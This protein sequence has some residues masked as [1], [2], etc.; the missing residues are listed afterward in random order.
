MFIVYLSVFAE[1]NY[2]RAFLP[3]SLPIRMQILHIHINI[4]IN[5]QRNNVP[6]I[7]WRIIRRYICACF[8][9]SKCIHINA[10]TVY[11]INLVSAYFPCFPYHSGFPLRCSP[12]E[13]CTRSA[14]TQRLCH[15]FFLPHLRA[16]I[17]IGRKTTVRNVDKTFLSDTFG[18][19]VSIPCS[20]ALFL[21]RTHSGPVRFDLMPQFLA[22]S[23]I[24]FT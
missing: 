14:S 24:Y 22:N 9:Q 4:C 18:G 23:H 21:H 10:E 8:P 17:A 20:L 13:N 12:N 1:T 6:T 11:E 16:A 19:R 3:L 2:S 15:P 5:T 7:G